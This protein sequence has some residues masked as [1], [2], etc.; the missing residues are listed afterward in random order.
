MGISVLTFDF[1]TFEILAVNPHTVVGERL[2]SSAHYEQLHGE[3]HGRI[4]AHY[5]YLSRQI[6]WIEPIAIACESPFINVRMPAAYGALTEVVSA[7]RDAVKF[8]DP[9]KPL[10]LIPPSLV[11][12]AVGARGNATKDDV[13]ACLAKL[14]EIVQRLTRPLDELDEHAIDA[15]AAAYYQ[16]LEYKNSTL[17]LI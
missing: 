8:T 17:P 16:F 3:R 10:Y 7:V 12:Q 1:L 5:R 6:E 14:P 13:K 11:K 2:R 9:L 15:T 4:D